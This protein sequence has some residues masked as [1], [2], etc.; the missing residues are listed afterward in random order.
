MPF[1]KWIMLSGFLVLTGTAYA[2]VQPALPFTLLPVNNPASSL[3]LNAGS[4][5]EQ[6]AAAKKKAAWEKELNHS[7]NAARAI[8]ISS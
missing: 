4:L 6:A 1:K 8:L 7:F 3:S 2:M 5:S